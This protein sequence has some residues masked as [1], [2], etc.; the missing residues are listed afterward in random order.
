EDRVD[1]DRGLAGGAVA[2][3]QLPL[4]APD[5]DHRVDRLDPGLERLLHR[6][7]GDDARRLELQRASLARLDRAAAV[8]RVPERVND[9]A[10]QRLADGNARHLAAAA[11]RLALLDV[12]PLPEEPRT[13]RVLLA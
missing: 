12:L 10:E 1:H 11:D 9:A 8:E 6:L 7:A 13:D 2:D 4:A 5:R 3:D